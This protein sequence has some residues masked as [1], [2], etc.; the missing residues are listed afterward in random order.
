MS[1][2]NKKGDSI[3]RLLALLLLCTSYNAHAIG[4][5]FSGPSLGGTFSIGNPIAGIKGGYEVTS[6]FANVGT[7]PSGQTFIDPDTGQE[8][9]DWIDPITHVEYQ[10]CRMNI[11]G[12]M[13][14]WGFGFNVFTGFFFKLDN[15]HSTPRVA[16]TG[17]SDLFLYDDGTYS[18]AIYTHSG[19]YSGGTYTVAG[20]PLCS[21]FPGGGATGG[22]FPNEAFPAPEPM[23]FM[24]LPA[25]L[26]A[27]VANRRSVMRNLASRVS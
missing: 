9:Y 19:I 14:G 4:I 13:S 17:H 24:L 22:C 15:S 16:S 7:C 18:H 3:M 25:V 5:S 2:T 27:L 20:F 21:P 11:I 8:W 1:P 6:F 23:A 26:L 12:G 10:D